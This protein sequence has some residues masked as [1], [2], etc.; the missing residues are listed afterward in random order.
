[1]GPV[2]LHYDNTSRP[3]RSAFSSAS[4]PYNEQTEKALKAESS[5]YIFTENLYFL[6]LNTELISQN[7]RTHWSELRKSTIFINFVYG[8]MQDIFLQ[9]VNVTVVNCG[10]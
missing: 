3:H 1:M 6:F 4:I 2:Q 5:V 7:F 8:R 10:V 9:D